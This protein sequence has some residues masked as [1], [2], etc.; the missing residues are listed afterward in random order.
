MT[1]ETWT[2]LKSTIE[3]GHHD[4]CR[5]EIKLKEIFWHATVYRKDIFHSEITHA[6]LL[7]IPRALFSVAHARLSSVGKRLI[8]YFANQL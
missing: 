8:Y 7:C 4:P 2:S 1:Q 6:Y 5:S 3:D